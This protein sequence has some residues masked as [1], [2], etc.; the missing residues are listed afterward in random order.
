ML[1]VTIVRKRASDHWVQTIGVF[2]AGDADP[3]SPIQAAIADAVIANDTTTDGR[4][5]TR[6][7][8]KLLVEGLNEENARERLSLLAHK[9][10]KLAAEPRVK[11]FPPS[12][13]ALN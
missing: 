4:Y 9:L 3:S 13:A 2:L 1:A 5:K 10:A 8:S 11:Y 7:M 6:T 12:T